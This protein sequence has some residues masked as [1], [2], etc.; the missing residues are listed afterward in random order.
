ML[1][2]IVR[3][4]IFGYAI[5]C[6]HG[7]TI[8]QK[9]AGV[10]LKQTGSKNAGASN[11]TV[12]LG[13]KFGALVAFIDIAKG[14]FSVIVIRLLSHQL[15]LSEDQALSLLFLV[16][17][18]TIIGHNYPF[19][20]GFNGGK[21]T[22]TLIGALFAID[23]RFGLIGFGLFV[24]AALA[25]DYIVFGVF[26]LYI[27]FLALA[28]WYGS[29]LAIAIAIALFLVGIVKHLENFSKIKEGSE[30]KISAVFGKKVK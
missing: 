27:T 24:I 14:A 15:N 9:I 18:A 7:S 1:T 13:K 17:V 3:I 11:A 2:W 25:T 16:S 6:L 30:T 20:M 12:V 8:V 10:N 4:I 19:Y 5:G 23:W 22:A 29:W 21:G 26:M 28:I